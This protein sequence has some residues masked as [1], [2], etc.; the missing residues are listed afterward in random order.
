MKLP[1]VD[2]DGFKFRRYVLIPIFNN[3]FGYWYPTTIAP[4]IDRTVT[5]TTHAWVASA[6]GCSGDRSATT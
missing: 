5:P 2:P 1:Q 4:R 3:R 6:P